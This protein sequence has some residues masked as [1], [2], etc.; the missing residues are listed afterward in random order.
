MWRARI[1]LLAAGRATSAD[2]AIFTPQYLHEI[3]RR[4]LPADTDRVSVAYSG[5][6]DSTVLLVAIAR[7][8]DELGKQVR[9]LHIDHQLQQ[10]S[11]HWAKRCER[12]ADELDV[13]FRHVR[14]DVNVGNEGVEAGA[15]RA[16]Y[17]AL[18]REMSDGEA[19]LTAHHADDQLETMLLALLRGAGPRGLSASPAVRS[20]GPGWLV[21]PLLDFTRS[22]LERWAREEQLTWVADPMNESI[23][24]DRNYLRH[25][26]VPRL[27]T[28][29]PAAALSAVRSATLVHE[30]AQLLETLAKI[31]MRSLGI[32]GCL[33]V[34]GLRELPGPRRRNVL[35][36]WL[37]SHGV[38]A[39]S[40][41][42]L[43]AIDHDMLVA[44]HDRVPSARVD[45]SE[46]RRH[47]NLLYCISTLPQVPDSALSWD[48]V[49][50]FVLPRGLGELRL[51]PT[52]GSGIATASLP[53]TL[54]VAFRRGGETLRAAGEAH[55]RSLKKR[56][57]EAN[58][59][60]WWRGRLPIIYAGD[61]LVA[62]GDLWVS[63]PF[64]A[65]AGEPGLRVVW[66][67]KPAMQPPM[68]QA[69]G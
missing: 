7:I 34:S 1:A 11:A 24:F 67:D 56:L 63:A 3:L 21:R 64:A 35:R 50:P 58:V 4:L 31:D 45:G 20:F 26:I 17:D 53:R 68:K 46:I 30:S 42:R 54:R 40:A 36:Q 15:R 66:I 28:R 19:L 61:R 52:V 27:R 60:P 43:A 41:R 23:S 49:S 25:E 37:R 39:P 65:Q 69:R 6:L 33:D 10:S 22:D 14:V 44:Q 16:R 59:L 48:V 12:T 18:R 38:R 62:V 9:A 51:E 8:R 55:R 47:R 13:P 57:Q 5:G 2:V 32:D 29:W